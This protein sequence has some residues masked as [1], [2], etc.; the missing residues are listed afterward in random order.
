M[1]N[2]GV[3]IKMANNLHQ[4]FLMQFIRTVR[5]LFISNLKVIYLPDQKEMKLFVP[6]MN[7]PFQFEPTIKQQPRLEPKIAL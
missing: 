4:N 7:Q 6:T 5:I 2:L 3:K 1:E